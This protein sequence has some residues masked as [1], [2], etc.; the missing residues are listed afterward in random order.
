[1]LGFY[2]FTRHLFTSTLQFQGS[3]ILL[4]VLYGYGS[5]K[6]QT[7][8]SKMK[9]AIFY[10]IIPLIALMFF[11]V[12]YQTDEYIGGVY[13]SVASFMILGVILYQPKISIFNFLDN[14]FFTYLGRISY[15][16]YLV[17]FSVLYILAR[18]MFI[19]LPGLSYSTNYLAIHSSL[20]VLSLLI[21]LP[22]SHLLNIYI[23]T[24]PVTFFNNYLRNKK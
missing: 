19:A 14:P 20:F 22:I 23:E 2:L 10:A 9:P 7:M 18:F 13:E 21:T 15:S 17:H 11:V 4:H 1:L 24:P 5:A 3:S 12:R 16:L 8:F 6:F